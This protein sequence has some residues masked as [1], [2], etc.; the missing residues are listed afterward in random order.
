MYEGQDD[1]GSEPFDQV[2]STL[3]LTILGRL[4]GHDFS[5]RY[6][7]VS[8][9]YLLVNRHLV[10]DNHWIYFMDGDHIINR[11]VEFKSL[12]PIDQ[13]VD[14]TVL[15]AE[16]TVDHADM[17]TRV[18]SELVECGVIRPEDVLDSLIL[19]ER[20]G[21]PVFD[22]EYA[23]RLAYARSHLEGLTNLHLLGRAAQ[24]EHLEVDDVF[25]SSL[26]LV[27]QL[28]STAAAPIV[29]SIESRG[30]L[31]PAEPSLPLVYA[32]VL[33]FNHY[34]D[35]AECLD[36]VQKS[37][38]ENLRIVLVDN[39]S[40]DGTVDKARADFPNVQVIASGGNLGVP[41]GY[42][43]GFSHALKS[44][45]QYVL[46]LNNDTIIDREMVRALV[47]AGEADPESG[48]LMP[49]VLY[50][51]EPQT[52]WAAG[53][54]HRRFP[55]AHVIVGQGLS[56]LDIQQPF[57]LEYALS[58]G[59]LIHQRAFQKAGLFDP[60]YFFQFDDWDFS[61]RVR[62]HGLHIMLIPSAQMWHKVSK[63]TREPGKEALFWRV[64]GESS[65]R[66][67]RRHGRPVFISLPMHLGVLMVREL[68]KGNGRCL[69]YFWAGVREGLIK[70]LGP[71]P[72]A[73]GPVVAATQVAA[74]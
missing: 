4:L 50:H 44:G 38:Y 48:I 62:A 15:C 69:K 61:Q 39:G 7:G 18:A 26:A 63:S 8:F 35:T 52:V 23:N 32:V 34:S 2:I 65:T 27:N 49:K 59:L 31:M 70:P 6:Q 16:V 5:L 13:P 29:N 10:T 11:L 74:P 67:Y 20:F 66:F 36:S 57:Q 40:A 37:D 68:I 56:T 30:D 47:N 21:Y 58:C 60:G 22:L 12:S 73:D 55:P 24:F 43:I 25:A 28:T 54:R 51:G 41:W 64:W 71:I 19:Q 17:A 42:N 53:G 14:H 45:A 9:V 46:M 33:S 1:R 3:P 72:Q